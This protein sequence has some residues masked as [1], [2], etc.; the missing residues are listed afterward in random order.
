MTAKKAEANATVFADQMK[1]AAEANA[2]RFA[3]GVEDYAV[4]ARET[5]AEFAKSAGV[6]NKAA[7]KIGAETVAVT[8]QSVKDGMTFVQDAAGAKSMA[9]LVE[10]QTNYMSKTCGEAIAKSSAVSD[11]ARGAMES[12]VEVAAGRMVAFAG[13]ARAY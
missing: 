3:K 11:V 8:M 10:L 2:K 9:E 12:A 4:F 13:L 5:A 7:E 6:A 1:S